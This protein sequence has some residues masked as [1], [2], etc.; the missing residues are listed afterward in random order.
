M[1]N[2]PMSLSTKN[3]LFIHQSAE[4]Y[5]SDKVLLNIVSRIDS[6]GMKPI[7]ILPEEGPLSRE[8][9]LRSI[10]FY[11]VPVSKVSRAVFSP[12]GLFTLWLE[13]RRSLR[14]IDG[15]LTGINIHVVYSNTIA[16][17]SGAIWAKRRRLPHI[18]HVHELIL[19]P[20]I[21]SFFFPNLVGFLSGR[22]VSISR[23]VTQ[24]LV[25]RSPSSKGKIA[26]ISN[27]IDAPPERSLDNVVKIRS[28]VGADDNT[29]LITLVGRINRWKGHGLLLDAIK[30][31][32]EPL[33][34]GCKFLMV[35]SAPPGQD[36]FMFDLEHRIMSEFPVG[37]ISVMPFTE[38]IWGR[39]ARY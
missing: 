18:W 23:M 16:V 38:S 26:T 33:L 8:L 14:E 22:I 35:G 32:P 10:E 37:L 34:S 19:S 36:F 7:V 21:V 12:R 20:K 3:V 9:A 29:V 1:V 28:S 25:L 24:W 27:G 31:L 13:I 11:V 17:L 6:Y 15:A 2:R 4:L 30:L 39:M 5:G